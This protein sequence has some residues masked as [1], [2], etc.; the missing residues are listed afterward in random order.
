MATCVPVTAEEPGVTGGTGGGGGNV[1][2]EGGVN[3]QMHWLYEEHEPELRPPKTAREDQ[4]AD[5]P[6]SRERLQPGGK[7]AVICVK[8]LE[9]LSG[10]SSAVAAALHSLVVSM[11]ALPHEPLSIA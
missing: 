4:P 10:R 11:I 3:M 6:S 2:R 7:G 8:S 9:V 1:G 5:P